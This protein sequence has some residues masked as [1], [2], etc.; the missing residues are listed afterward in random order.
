MPSIIPIVTATLGAR[1]EIA[2]EINSGLADGSFRLAGGVV[3]NV[4]DGRVVT[5]LRSVSDGSPAAQSAINALG[6]LAQLN[7]ALS[8]MDLSITAAG[9]AN[10]VKKLGA[11]EQK[12][13]SISKTLEG[14]GRKLDLSFCANLRAALELARTAFA[15]T[16]ESNRK[17]STAFWRQSISTHWFDRRRTRRR[18]LGGPAATP[19]THAGDSQRFSLLP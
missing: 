8:V 19:L 12:L 17:L 5:W 10:V 6:P 11:I 1:P 18:W 7:V 16:G 13:T 3:Q 15:M 9:F 2:E 4:K 14:I